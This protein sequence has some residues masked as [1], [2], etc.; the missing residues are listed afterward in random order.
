MNRSFEKHSD[1]IELLMSNREYLYRYILAMVPHAADAEDLLQ[2]TCKLIWQK[3]EEYQEGTSFKNWA[4]TIARYNVLAYYRS[5]QRNR[6]KFSS[7]AIEAISEHLAE[8]QDD[9]TREMSTLKDCISKLTEKDRHLIQMRYIQDVPT[10]QLAV[11]LGRPL[12]S[13]YA[14]LARIHRMLVDC[15][16]QNSA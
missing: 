6:V 8:C 5:T 7:Q 1:Y 10:K 12:S 3:F 2:E 13:V 15:V 16:Q 14:V 11:Q 9:I 4:I